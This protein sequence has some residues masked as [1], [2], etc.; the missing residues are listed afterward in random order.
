MFVPSIGEIKQLKY[1][2]E[3]VNISFGSTS[4][5]SRQDFSWVCCTLEMLLHALEVEEI[6][7]CSGNC[8]GT[9]SCSSWCLTT[10]TRIVFATTGKDFLPCRLC[11]ESIGCFCSCVS[12]MAF[13]AAEQLL[14]MDLALFHTLLSIKGRMI[15]LHLEF[16]GWNVLL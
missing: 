9:W 1:I 15:N 14:V 13:V 6:P 5:C 10:W 11:N 16:L 12:S 8:H 7:L 3:T 2:S 4:L